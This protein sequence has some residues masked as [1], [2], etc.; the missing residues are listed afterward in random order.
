MVSECHVTTYVADAGF[1][2]VELEGHCNNNTG[3]DHIKSGHGSRKL[4]RVFRCCRTRIPKNISDLVKE[5]IKMR[6]APLSIGNLE[7]MMINI[8]IDIIGT[9]DV[10]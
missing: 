10:Q 1:I 5:V 4:G 3:I 2:P 6:N 8:L 9:E 7:G